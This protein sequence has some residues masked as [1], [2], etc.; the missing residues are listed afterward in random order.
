MAAPNKKSDFHVLVV[1]AGSV[2]LLIAQRL[3]ILGIKCTVFERE[4]YLNERPRDWS[5]GIYWAQSSLTECLPNSLLSRLNTAQVDPLRT[6]T[7]DD[8]LRILNGKTAEELLRAPT[9]NV[10]R[11]RRS[12]FRAL[13]AD[14]VDVQVQY[15]LLEIERQIA[16]ATY[17]P[18]VYSSMEKD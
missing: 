9:P 5:F 2:G 16:V 14:G 12:K 8:Y 3:K 6:S 17:L 18:N 1:G 11:L 7:S 4:Y 13:L 10:Y 15:P